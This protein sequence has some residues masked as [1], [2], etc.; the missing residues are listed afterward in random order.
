MPF[1]DSLRPTYDLPL[2]DLDHDEGSRGL[3]F[4]A[5]TPGIAVLD[6]GCDTGRFGEALRVRKAAVVDG[7]ERDPAAAE[8]ARSRLRAVWQ[9]SLDD[10]AAFEGLG[11]YD[12]V[13]F[14]DV[15][16]HLFDPW[17][18]LRNAARVLRPG[19]AVHAVVPN[20]AHVSVVRRLAQGRFEYADFG[21]MD[22]THVRWFTRES[23]RSCF[24]SAGLERI[25]VTS[26]P[27]IPRLDTSRPLGAR[28]ARVLAGALPDAFG[29]SLYA[30]GFAPVT[31]SSP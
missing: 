9:R 3:V 4:R 25:A 28:L 30:T 29:G 20:V 14:L 24:A 23:I 26:V 21:T 10:A 12:A 6:V 19:G 27:V 17:Q 31:T 8:Q 15:L 7:I 18:V 2:G 5:L 13:L 22:R 1:S 16:E 11:P